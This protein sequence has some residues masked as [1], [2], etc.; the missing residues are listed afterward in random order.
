MQVTVEKPEI[1]T[2]FY[3]QKRVHKWR[4]HNGVS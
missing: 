3:K 2:L 1:I 4:Y